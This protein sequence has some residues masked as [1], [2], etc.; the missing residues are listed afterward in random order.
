MLFCKSPWVWHFSFIPLYAGKKA[1]LQCCIFF[2]LGSKL[3]KSSLKPHPDCLFS[4]AEKS[5]K[6][7]KM[8]V[9]ISCSNS[10]VWFQIPTATCYVTL[11]FTHPRSGWDM[12]FKAWMWSPGLSVL[13]AI[14][15]DS[16]FSIGSHAKVKQVGWVLLFTWRLI[17][18]M[19][20]AVERHN[21][22]SVLQVPTLR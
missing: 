5:L 6:G 8:L 13:I 22:F 3:Q 2:Y 7:R 17:E 18:E 4:H 12:S 19:Y 9:P 16:C 10:R 1:K 20:P 14:Q 21:D 11:N 15:I